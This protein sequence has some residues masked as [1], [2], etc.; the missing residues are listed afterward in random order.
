MRTTVDLDEDLLD[1]L[2]AEAARRHVPFKHLLNQVLRAGLAGRSAA[3][4]APYRCP[5][6][7]M[8]APPQGV[9]LDKALGVADTL[10]DDAVG[11]KLDLRK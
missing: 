11:H 7:S 1:R 4:V 9:N 3:P 6:R 10:A 2:R 5:A 8:G